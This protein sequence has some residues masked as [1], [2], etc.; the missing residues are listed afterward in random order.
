MV[1][2]LVESL[3]GVD[4]A[5]SS[6]ESLAGRRWEVS[7]FR[8]CWGQEQEQEQKQEQEQEQQQCWLSMSEGATA[9]AADEVEVV[10][11][12][13]YY[14]LPGPGHD[15]RSRIGMHVCVQFGG[16]FQI[17]SGREW[18]SVGQDVRNGALPRV[19]RREWFIVEGQL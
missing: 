3:A 17:G 13:V 1:Q 6:H 11:T 5:K 16:S 2:R 10:G 7:V 15:A 9:A 14:Y 8:S 12:C 4:G 18:C 19:W